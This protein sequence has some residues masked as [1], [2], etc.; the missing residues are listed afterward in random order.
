MRIEDIE[1]SLSIQ[2]ARFNWKQEWNHLILT[3][4]VVGTDEIVREETHTVIFGLIK[5]LSRSV[6]LKWV[7]NSIWR[8]RIPSDN[9]LSRDITVPKSTTGCANDRRDSWWFRD[10]RDITVP[11]STTGSTAHRN[12]MLIGDRLGFLVAPQH[13]RMFHGR[14]A[15]K[16]CEKVHNLITINEVMDG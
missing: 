2:K 16:F 6:R 8:D 3:A 5:I 10:S 1:Y 7:T 14:E 9:G 11:K 15:R 13:I 12:L 4:P